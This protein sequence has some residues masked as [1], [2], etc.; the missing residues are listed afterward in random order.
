MLCHKIIT[1]PGAVVAGGLLIRAPEPERRRTVLRMICTPRQLS[2]GSTLRLIAAV[3]VA[4]LMSSCSATTNHPAADSATAVPASGTSQATSTSALAVAESMAD[5]S[6]KVDAALKQ[7]ATAI[8]EF[9]GAM[10]D[11][12]IADLGTACTDVDNAQLAVR[13]NLPA[14]DAAVNAK[15]VDYVDDLHAFSGKCSAFDQGGTNAEGDAMMADLQNAS[16][17]LT[18]A[19]A[20]IAAAMGGKP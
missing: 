6:A 8:N 10:K 19:L 11:G 18:D 15:M 7:S 13:E 2:R 3:G 20:A 16:Q 4:I 12:R 17:E 1:W 14:P 9:A 5:W